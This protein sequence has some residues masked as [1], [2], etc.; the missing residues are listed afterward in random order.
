MDENERMRR[1]IAARIAVSEIWEAI[2]RVEKLKD[3]IDDRFYN[4][5]P[6]IG[7]KRDI[8]TFERRIVELNLTRTFA[9]YRRPSADETGEA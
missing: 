6:M 1:A 3:Y 9:P 2:E 4:Y 8:E 7:N 5:Q